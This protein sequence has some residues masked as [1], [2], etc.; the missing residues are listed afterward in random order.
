MS[1]FLSANKIKQYKHN[2]DLFCVFLNRNYWKMPSKGNK[3]PLGPF[4]TAKK[5]PAMPAVIDSA[6]ED[7]LTRKL[8]FFSGNKPVHR[9]C[10]GD[11][12]LLKAFL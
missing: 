8:Y 10:M 1:L 5:W 4:A 12:C 3:G 11:R 7:I 2:I 9:H 6:F